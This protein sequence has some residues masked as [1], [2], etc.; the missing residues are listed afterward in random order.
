VDALLAGTEITQTTTKAIGCGIKDKR[1]K[2]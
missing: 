1:N 2:K